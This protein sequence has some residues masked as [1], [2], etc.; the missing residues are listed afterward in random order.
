MLNVNT[1]E[2]ADSKYRRIISDN[3]S[4]TYERE[5]QQFQQVYPLDEL[6]NRLGLIDQRVGDATDI[7]QRKFKLANDQINS[8]VEKIN[9]D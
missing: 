9:E 8:T 6:E 4:S 7:F 2:D 5:S 3:H 1:M